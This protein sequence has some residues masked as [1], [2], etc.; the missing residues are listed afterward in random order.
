MMVECCLTATMTS[1]GFHRKNVEQNAPQPVH[2]TPMNRKGVKDAQQ[3]KDTQ[4]NAEAK[5]SKKVVK[6]PPILFLGT[7]FCCA[8]LGR[9]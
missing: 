5:W 8:E 6:M 7:F 3:E 2:A 1:T 9:D 4:P